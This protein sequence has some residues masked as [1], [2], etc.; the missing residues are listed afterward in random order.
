MIRDYLSSP[1]YAPFV[2]APFS[3]SLYYDDS[4][5]TLVEPVEY[6]TS[7]SSTDL[8]ASGG[9]TIAGSLDQND[10]TFSLTAQPIGTTDTMTFSI[11]FDN[12]FETSGRPSVERVVKYIDGH[13]YLELDSY[14]QLTPVPIELSPTFA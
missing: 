12:L 14:T 13:Q 10:A 1:V 5:C 4:A 11:G 9:P 3:S 8:G 2:V 6:F 7:Y